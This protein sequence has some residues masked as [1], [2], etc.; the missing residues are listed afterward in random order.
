[1]ADATPSRLPLLSRCCSPWPWWS[2]CSSGRTWAAHPAGPLTVFRLRQPSA[3]DKIGQVLDLIDR[4]YVDTVEKNALV[5]EVLQDILQRLDPHSYYISAAE[6]RA[7]QEPLEGSF[8]GIGVEFAIQ[9]DTVVVIAPV[10]GGPSEAV[11]HPGGRPHPQGG[12]YP[13]GRGEHHERRCD[14]EPARTEGQ[15]GHGLHPAWQPQGTLRSDDH[16]GQDP[17]Q[18]RGR[19]DPG[20]PTA[21]ATSSWCASRRTPTQEF[22]KAADDL[23]AQGMKRMVLD[24]RGNGGGFLNS[25]IDL[26]DEFLPD[27]RTDRVHRG[28]QLTRA[29]TSPPPARVR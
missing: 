3:G 22:L 28:P 27:G 7:A 1:M 13:A 16:P 11:G 25:A 2:A 10:E 20:A 24:L 8:D 4:Q 29:A 18:Q 15:H 5:D 19:S 6:L 12:Q 14:E 23:K 17:H 26:A 9:R 21:P